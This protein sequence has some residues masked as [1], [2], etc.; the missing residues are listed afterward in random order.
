MKKTLSL[1]L[2][3]MMVFSALAVFT[4]SSSA[5]DT[6][7]VT[8]YSY[9]E[10][11]G[12]ENWASSTPV[13]G[14]TNLLFVVAKEDAAV[15]KNCLNKI[16]ELTFTANGTSKTVQ[17]A[18]SSSTGYGGG[19]IIRFQPMFETESNRFVPAK[20]TMYTVSGRVLNFN[21]TTLVNIAGSGEWGLNTDAV[22][23]T[24]PVNVAVAPK[25]GQFENYQGHTVML[26]GVAGG[27]IP[28]VHGLYAGNYS[29]KAVITD[30][31]AN[32][33]YT[34]SKWAFDSKNEKGDSWKLEEANYYNGLI[35]LPVCEYG[36]ELVKGNKY[37]VALEISDTATK[38]VL[39]KGTSATGAFSTWKTGD[40]PIV[41]ETITHYYDEHP[42]NEKPVELTL[43]ARFGKIENWSGRTWFIIGGIEKTVLQQLG[44]GKLFAKAVVTDET[45]NKTY[46]ISKYA[47]D[48]DNKNEANVTNSLFRLAACEYGIVPVNGHVYT[49]SVEITD[50]TGSVKYTGSSAKGAFDK[51]NDAFVADGAIKPENVT[52]YYDEYKAPVNPP[53]T[54]EH[55]AVIV[56][57]AVVALFGSAVVVSK[58]VFDK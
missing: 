36:I 42:S 10:L 20:G 35:R 43:T 9:G 28:L 30:E 2:V 19:Y 27:Y 3:I 26:V 44:E 17:M 34:V 24:F 50:A 12:I 13:G 4:V 54:G 1:A 39:F 38:E 52:H 40:D 32:K 5:E 15:A 53:V 46:T 21:G 48:V 14:Q 57:L 25:Y 37:T 23:P 45:E 16:W 22:A 56:V 51:G 33:T 41:P 11:K 6:I 58:K 31:T 47:F 29:L 55:T 49:I 7:T 18:V 8:P